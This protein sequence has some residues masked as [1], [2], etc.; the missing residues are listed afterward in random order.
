M[1]AQPIKTDDSGEWERVRMRRAQ[2]VDS[3][4][5]C[6]HKQQAKTEKTRIKY[7]RLVKKVTTVEE[8]YATGHDHSRDHNRLSTIATI[9][10]DDRDRLST[11]TGHK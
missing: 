6:M 7:Q 4:C 10:R 9:F 8:Y 5:A 3:L 1:A 2:M 11:T